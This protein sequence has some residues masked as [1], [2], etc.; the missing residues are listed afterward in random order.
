MSLVAPVEKA[1]LEPPLR[2][3]NNAEAPATLAQ[4]TP[5][6][7]DARS[8]VE[9][10]R[11]NQRQADNSPQAE[12][13]W[14]FQEIAQ[15]S[16]QTKQNQAY[17]SMVQ[18]SPHAI[19]LAA[20][21][22]AMMKSNAQQSVENEAPLPRKSNPVEPVEEQGPPQAGSASE[23]TAQFVE[24]A[25]VEPNNT[26]LPNRLKCGVES[27]SGMSLDHVKVHYN[28][29]KPAQLNAH[30]YAQGEEIHLAPGQEPHLPHEAWHIVQQA[31]GRVQP[32]LQMQQA[33]GVV[34]LLGKTGHI[35]IGA[36]LG[37]VIPILGTILGGYIGY[38]IWKSKNSTAET[39]SSSDLEAPTQDD[40]P[41]EFKGRSVQEMKSLQIQLSDVRSSGGSDEVAGSAKNQRAGRADEDGQRPGD[42]ETA[43]LLLARILAIKEMIVGKQFQNAY[44]ALVDANQARACGINLQIAHGNGAPSKLAETNMSFAKS[45]IIKIYVPVNE[46]WLEDEELAT[47][48]LPM[49]LE[50]YM[51]QYQAMS[52]QF[53]SANTSA[54][55]STGTTPDQS[56]TRGFDDGDYDEIDVMAALIDWGFDVQKIGYVERYEEREDYWQWWSKRTADL[57]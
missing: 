14:H 13:Q 34:Q 36:I 30:A 5:T 57:D 10:H 25:A 12:A 26:G 2:M 43:P 6:F 32:T 18:N 52:N 42:S 37:T 19:Q 8:H 49:H 3:Q 16:A 51:H 50:E 53:I 17:N 31:Q 4:L 39:K 41:E 55:K 54:F 23:Q 28:S 11:K 9:M 22:R 20:A 29:D 56:V 24:N 21:K 46:A 45:R 35:A 7:V 38:R 33:G 44:A 1:R 48:T 27:L 47:L 40:L 15:L